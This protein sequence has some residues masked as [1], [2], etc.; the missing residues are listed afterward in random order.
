[1][2][3]A[4][5]VTACL[6]LIFMIAGLVIRRTLVVISVSGPSMQPALRD[7]DRLLARRA[8]GSLP[9]PG[10]LVIF[11]PLMEDG[12]PVPVSTPRGGR[13]W[14][15]KRLVAGP[16][17]PVPAGFDP[18][19]RELTDQPVPAGFMV[20]VGDNLAESVD[21]RQEGFVAVERIRARVVRQLTS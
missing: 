14:L 11:A 10:E 9:A 1:M 19:L 20:V 17:Q 3:I 21:S 7:G 5:V 6:A 16:G 12:R 15:V 4:I 8:V 13:L 18:A 2:T